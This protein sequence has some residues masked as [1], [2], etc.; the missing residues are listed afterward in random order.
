MAFGELFSAEVVVSRCVELET[1]AG[2]NLAVRFNETSRIASVN[3]IPISTTAYDIVGERYVF[4]AIEGILSDFGYV[5]CSEDPLDFSPVVAA[6]KYGTLL[7]LVG[8]SSLVEEI[9]MLRPVS[10]LRFMT[11][12]IQC[13]F[14]EVT[15]FYFNLFLCSNFGADRQWFCSGSRFH[16]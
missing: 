1:F 11:S 6:G 12:F 7:D 10:K 3:G 13:E 2:T 14:F 15:S 9:G 5:P 4:H 16:I 8:Q